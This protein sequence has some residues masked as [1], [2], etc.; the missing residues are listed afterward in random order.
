MGS[1]DTNRQP[2]SLSDIKARL[3]FVIAADDQRVHITVGRCHIALPAGECDRLCQPCRRNLALNGGAE[4]GGFAHN[5][6]EGGISPYHLEKGGDLIWQVGTAYFGCRTKDGNFSD[7]LFTEKAMLENVKMIEIK[8]SQGAK[9]GHGG[10]L[11]AVKN[12]P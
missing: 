2:F 9:P 10:I 11:P 8:L 3:A 1:L 7:E 6:G 5:T 4:A 12:T